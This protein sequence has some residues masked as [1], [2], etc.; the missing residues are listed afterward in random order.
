MFIRSLLPNE[1]QK[2]VGSWRHK[3][4]C[5]EE[6]EEEEEEDED[7]DEEEESLSKANWSAT[8]QA[9]Q[10]RERTKRTGACTQTHSVYFR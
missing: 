1:N 10:R 5:V 7:E 4:S 8:R 2:I 9:L 6:E 3:H